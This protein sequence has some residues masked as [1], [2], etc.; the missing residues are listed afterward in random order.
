MLGGDGLQDLTGSVSLPNPD[1]Q[2]ELT[3]LED[4]I[5]PEGVN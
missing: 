2:D 1:Q 4:I 3:G 5:S